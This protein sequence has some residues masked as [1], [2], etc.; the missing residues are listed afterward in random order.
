MTFELGLERWVEFWQVE[1]YSRGREQ[2][3]QRSGKHESLAEVLRWQEHGAWQGVAG[4]KT[5]KVRQNWSD[6]KAKKAAIF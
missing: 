2:S 1:R 5:R 3:E 6:R 4:D